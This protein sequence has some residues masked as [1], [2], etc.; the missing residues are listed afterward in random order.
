[1]RDI[2]KPYEIYQHFKGKYYQI[3]NIAINSETNEKMVVYQ[4]LYSPFEVYVRPLEMFMSEVDRHK[5]PMAAQKYR[6]QKIQK[7]E[8]NEVVKINPPQTKAFD[9][10]HDDESALETA[11]EQVTINPGLLAFLEA[12]TYEQKLEILNQLHSVITDEMIDTMA[13]SLDIEIKSGELEARYSEMLN[14]LL[15]MERFECNRLR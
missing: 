1:M 7:N 6:F 11:S 14:C 9:E 13:V 5:Y 4:Q 15:T 3:L 10:E 12:D 2:P 8:V